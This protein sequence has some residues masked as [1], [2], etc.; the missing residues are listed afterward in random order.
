MGLQKQTILSL[1]Y[2]LFE[3]TYSPVYEMVSA[4]ISV[5]ISHKIPSAVDISPLKEDTHFHFTC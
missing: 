2:F 3:P 5:F 4:M 1:C